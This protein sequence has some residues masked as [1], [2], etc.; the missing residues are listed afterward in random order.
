M[1][2]RTAHNAIAAVVEMY[3]CALEESQVRERALISEIA[4]LRQEN[5]KL[6]A[7]AISSSDAV[8]ESSAAASVSREGSAGRD[9]PLNSGGM[10]SSDEGK[11]D[12]KRP[13][14]RLGQV[15]KGAS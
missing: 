12:S 3:A 6:K 5:V 13:Q 15:G 4:M 8:Q 9:Q 10:G 1:T 7:A 11:E 2:P 14:E